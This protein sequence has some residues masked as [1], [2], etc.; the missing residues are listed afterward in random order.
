MRSCD[1]LYI[2]DPN[3]KPKNDNDSNE[4]IKIDEFKVR[5]ILIRLDQKY[6]NMVLEKQDPTKILNQIKEIRMSEANVTTISVRKVLYNTIYNPNKEKASEFIERFDELVRQ[7]NN[8]SNFNKM[9]KDEKRDIFFTNVYDS[10]PTIKDTDFMMRNTHKTGLSY[11]KLKQYILQNEANQKSNNGL[12]SKSQT[13][14]LIASYK[15]LDNGHYA[16]DCENDGQKCYHCKQFRNHLADQ[17]PLR[18]EQERRDNY[19]RG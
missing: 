11:E 2:I 7:Y 3:E 15:C 4:N 19:I 18:L 17:C 5:E 9:S 14:A 16:K 1:L 6:Q 8:I 10:V 12:T 13:T